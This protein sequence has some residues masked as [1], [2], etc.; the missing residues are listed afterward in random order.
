[1]FGLLGGIYAWNT[2][3]STSRS[4]TR[5]TTTTA[6]TSRTTTQSTSKSTTTTYNT[7][8][9]STSGTL[10]SYPTTHFWRWYPAIS[11]IAIRYSNSWVYVASGSGS[12]TSI[13]SGGFTYLRGTLRRVDAGSI[14][15]YDFERTNSTSRSTSRSTT[16][17]FDTS[18]T[19][20]FDTSATTTT[21][22]TTTFDTQRETNYYA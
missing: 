7:S 20:T 21:T 10:Y 1:M 14:E 2:T 9:T 5:D 13:T 8:Y 17:T 18:F 19:T 3:V 16:T 11:E 15:H 4:T 22:F 6:S 12:T